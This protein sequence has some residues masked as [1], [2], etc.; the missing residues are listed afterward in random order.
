VLNALLIFLVVLLAPASPHKGGGTVLLDS[1]ELKYIKR[2][3]RAINMTPRDLEYFKEWAGPDSFRLRRVSQLMK[4][5]LKVPGY[6]DMTRESVKTLSDSLPSLLLFMGRETDL[7][8]PYDRKELLKRVAKRLEERSTVWSDSVKAFIDD[9]T[10][11]S[12]LSILLA[13]NEISS[14]LIDSAFIELTLGERDTLLREAIFLWSD[15]DDSTDDT[16]KGVLPREFGVEIDTSGEIKAK[17]I[18]KIAQKIKR[19]KI[20]EAG[21]V[22]FV[23]LS[24]ALQDI[25]KASRREF[26]IEREISLGRIAI[27]G[28]GENMYRGDYA[29]I[30]DLGGDDHYEGRIGGG[31]GLIKGASPVAYVIDLGGDDEYISKKTVSQGAGV[32]G[33]GIIFD[34][35]GNDYYRAS[36]VS[37]GAGLFGVGALIDGGGDDTYR[38]GFF[39]QGAGNFGFGIIFDKK[40]NDSYRAIDWTQGFGSVWGY[41]MLIEKGG[42]DSYYAGGHYIHHPLLPH[43]Y[44]SFAQGFGMGWRSDASGG[45]G[46]LLD[47][48]G[49][50]YYYVEVYG[51]GTSYWY[52]LGMLVDEGGNDTYSAAEYAQGAGI[53]LSIGILVDLSGKDH[54][55]SRYGPSQGEGHDLAVGWL[56]DKGGDDSYQVSGGQGI[57]L[58]NSVG[59][60]IDSGGND[61]YLT[62]EKLGQGDANWTRGFGGIGIFLDLDGKDTYKGAPG[63]DNEWWIQGTFG[64][65]ID[66]EGK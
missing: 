24:E 36:H 58:T 14:Q 44:R 10:L 23:A 45:M 25:Q 55:F 17:E 34:E 29:L 4:K 66:E 63:S 48:G 53:H 61:T 59:I 40:G 33:V 43:Q 52:S 30:V 3:L 5:P 46:L 22:S 8:P 56:I 9:S 60:F 57:G 2:A 1:L 27:G 47:S 13:G 35:K 62:T 15:E 32:F 18:L 12:G 54:Y 21:L 37:E 42:N 7:K 20:L 16:L 31:I 41:G 38:S 65:G 11:V 26:L 19:E 28:I 51:Q 49:N 39:A 50:D 6:T 64:V